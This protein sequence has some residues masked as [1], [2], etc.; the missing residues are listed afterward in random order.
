MSSSTPDVD[1]GTAT[2]Y[3]GKESVTNIVNW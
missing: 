2:T 1:V 3:E